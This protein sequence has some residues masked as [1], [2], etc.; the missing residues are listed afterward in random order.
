MPGIKPF[1]TASGSWTETLVSSHSRPHVS[2]DYPYSKSQ[3]KRMK[4][5]P[6]FP[7]RFDS[8]EDGRAFLDG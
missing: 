6:G 2:D 4:Y 7:D 3:F 8:P 1:V 5:S